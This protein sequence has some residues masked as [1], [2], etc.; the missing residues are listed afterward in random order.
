VL[1]KFRRVKADYYGFSFGKVN[2]EFL[3]HIALNVSLFYMI[4]ESNFDFVF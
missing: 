1:D 3:S 4:V 2:K